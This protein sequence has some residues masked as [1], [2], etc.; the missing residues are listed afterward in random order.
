M[1]AT[2]EDPGADEHGV[3]DHNLN[4]SGT[5]LVLRPQNKATKSG[6]FS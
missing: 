6:V 5:E 3:R 4:P 2:D 1:C